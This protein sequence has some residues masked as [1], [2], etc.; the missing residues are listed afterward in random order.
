MNEWQLIESAPRDGSEILA[1][2]ADSGL[3]LVRW[4]AICDFMTESEVAAFLKEY[5]LTGEEEWLEEPDWFYA[6]FV[7]GGRLD[8]PPTHWMLPEPPGDAA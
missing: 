4:I 2:R 6:D 5:Q 8:E 1:W 7:Q 3:L